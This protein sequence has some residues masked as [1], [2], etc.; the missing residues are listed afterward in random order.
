MPALSH[1]GPKFFCYKGGPLLISAHGHM[2]GKTPSLSTFTCFAATT[3]S[4]RFIRSKNMSQ[5][6]KT[7]VQY[8]T[9]EEDSTLD[10]DGPSEQTEAKASTLNVYS[11]NNVRYLIRQLW[12]I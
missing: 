6:T 10:L 2:L 1:L 11:C 4:A 7:L 3:L 9:K 8:I 12:F 5:V